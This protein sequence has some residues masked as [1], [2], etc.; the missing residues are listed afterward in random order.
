MKKFTLLSIIFLCATTLS[1][2]QNLK[3]ADDRILMLEK[4]GRAV[5]PAI[6]QNEYVGSIG[7]SLYFIIDHKTLFK[8]DKLLKNGTSFQLDKAFEDQLLIKFSSQST[9]G[10]ISIANGPKERSYI[11]N[12]VFVNGNGLS[13]KPLKTIECEKGDYYMY[14]VS[15]SID[16]SKKMVAISLVS[17]K[18]AYKF[19]TIFVINNEGEIIWSKTISPKFKND[20]FEFHSMTVS[21]NGSVYILANSFEIGVKNCYLQLI[22]VDENG[23]DR[24]VTDAFPFNTI[25]AMRI[26]ELSN[27]NLFIGGYYT[28][29]GVYNY[30][31]SSEQLGTF[32]YV[33]SK[34]LEKINFKSKTL[35]ET[36]PN[37]LN[38]RE[39][40][41]PTKP[42]FKH[43][44]GIYETSDGKVTMLAEEQLIISNSYMQKNYLR[45]NVIINSFDLNGNYEN[46]SILFKDQ[47]CQ[48]V[49]VLT[50]FDVI[51]NN[52]ELIL[53]YNDN[54]KNEITKNLPKPKR[55]RVQ[56]YKKTGQTIA[57]TIK[58]GLVDKKRVLINAKKHDGIFYSVVEIF[59]KEA[60]IIVQTGMGGVG[61]L[62]LEKITW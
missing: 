21:N 30:T 24:N 12:K 53:I 59:D 4:S 38:M 58:D 15:T 33:F 52:D 20:K 7:N 47:I 62:V 37:N 11:L 13:E 61:P 45:Y 49:N 39:V 50:S 54:V 56:N 26:I 8:T 18:D 28:T 32:S 27:G 43:I 19:T 10:F 17:S 22:K 36:T 46:S 34:S 57:C 5:N 2:A 23:I 44:K 55:I 41:P 6:K 48:I 14:N 42:N 3:V 16:K 25:G 29:A 60:I 51:K 40:Y 1:N 31:N 35:V 9:A